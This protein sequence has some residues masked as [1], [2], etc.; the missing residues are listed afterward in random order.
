MNAEHVALLI[1][2]VALVGLAVFMWAH[3]RK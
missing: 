2:I 3:A 1:T